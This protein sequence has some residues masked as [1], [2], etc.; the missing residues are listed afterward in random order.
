MGGLLTWAKRWRR[1]WATGRGRV[2]TAVNGVSSPIANVGSL[3]SEAIGLS[4]IVTS[5]LLAPKATWWWRRSSAAGGIC[6]GW[7]TA[8]GRSPSRTHVA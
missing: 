8:V 3:P 7:P 5:S 2:A 4:T 1:K 6:T